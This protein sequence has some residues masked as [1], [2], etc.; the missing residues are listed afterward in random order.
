ML[1]EL[2]FSLN[3]SRIIGALVVFTMN[4]GSKY[5]SK[6]MPLAVDLIFENYW[7]RMLVVFCIAYVSTKD[8]FLAL[9][10]VLFYILLFAYMLN[11][12]SKSCILSKT[13]SQY[14]KH[15]EKGK[16]QLGPQ[17]IEPIYDINDVDV[18]KAKEILRKY[19]LNKKI[20]QE[21]GDILYF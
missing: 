8:I 3:S 15:I 2:L 6:D 4:I 10:I 1:S 7:A 19:E 11:E 17:K 13:V 12:N 18:I 5:I 9:M 21:M 20:N 14:K 16:Q